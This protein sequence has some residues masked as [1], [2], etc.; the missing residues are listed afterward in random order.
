MP[1]LTKYFSV[2][3]GLL[4]LCGLSHAQIS[5]RVGDWW[6]HDVSSERQGKATTSEV[7][8]KVVGLEEGLM[9]LEVTTRWSEGERKTRETR[10]MNLNIVQSGNLLYKP[11][12]DFFHMPLAIGKRS[13]AIERVQIDS[14]RVIKMAGEVSVM[15]AQKILTGAGEFDGQEVVADRR[16]TDPKTG[17]SSRY[18]TRAWFAPAVDFWVKQEFFERNIQDTADFSRTKI[19]LKAFQLQPR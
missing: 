18:Q 3:F 6:T 2:F 1:S 12:L 13:Y 10:D 8:R 16:F 17:D 5:P 19:L 11:H 9:I 4:L 15:P 7:T 14:G